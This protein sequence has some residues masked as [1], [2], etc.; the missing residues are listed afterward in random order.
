MTDTIYPAQHNN[1]FIDPQNCGSSI[2]Y[3]IVIEE[4][5]ARK[6]DDIKPMVVRATV[7]LADCSHK[8][9]WE[10]R[11]E[12]AEVEKIDEAIRVLQE[13]RKKWIAAEKF[14]EQLNRRKS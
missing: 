4:G 8:I 6:S 13:F 11:T 2:G 7:T 5:Y 3:R 10:F 14:A 12:E 9:D 1:V